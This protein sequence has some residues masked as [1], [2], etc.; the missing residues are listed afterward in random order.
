MSKII[1]GKFKIL[2]NKKIGP[3]YFKMVIAASRIARN[4]Q[5][6]QFVH[7]R[8]HDSLQPLLRRPFSFHRI[9]KQNFEVLYQA[10]GR[11]TKLLAK[12]QKGDTIDV[13]G[14]LGNGFELAGQPIL[15]AGG[16]G[17]AP[18][19]A[20][21]ESFA[22]RKNILVLIGAKT[23]KEVLCVKE[24]KRLGAKVGVA[25]DDGS[26][27]FKGLVTDLLTKALR[28]KKSGAGDRI[29]TCGPKPMLKV[30]ARISKQYRLLCQG[31]LEEKMACGVGACL[32]CAV[33][34]VTGYQKVC[35]DGPV[36]DL[37]DIKW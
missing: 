8:C 14:P 1:Q 26:R 16:M 12:R 36:F 6:G 4:A 34:T 29:Y 20:L 7:L 33:Q 23:K 10:I 17:V 37:Q 13:L 28:H 5:P 30:V 15:V 22:Q 27:G 2:S 31:S 18:L 24:F 25:T 11:G 35:Q 21:A 32:G 3:D 9:K 19:L